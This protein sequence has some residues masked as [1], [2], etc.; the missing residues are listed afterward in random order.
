MEADKVELSGLPY[1]VDNRITDGS[2]VV[3]LNAPAL[4][5]SQLCVL[6]QSKMS[7]IYFLRDKTCCL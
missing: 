7:N 4:L 5:H 6:Y 1:F 3:R 2:D